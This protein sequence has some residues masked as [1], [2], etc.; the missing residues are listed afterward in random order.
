MKTLDELRE[1][2]TENGLDAY[3]DALAP[4]AKNAL[5]VTLDVQDDEDRPLV[6]PNLAAPPTCLPV[7]SGSAPA[8]RTFP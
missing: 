4:L 8:K 5:R 7:W 3:F 6:S 1:E 2:M